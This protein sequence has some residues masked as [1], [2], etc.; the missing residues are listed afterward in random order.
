MTNLGR[1]V[2]CFLVL[3]AAAAGGQAPSTPDQ[4]V[5]SPD[6]RSRDQEISLGNALAAQFLR[7]TPTLDDNAAFLDYVKRVGANLAAQ[8]PG[9]WTYQ[10]YLISGDVGCSSDEPTVFP[11]GHIFVPQGLI[12]A[13]RNEAEFV[14]MLAH[15]M[16]H[17]AEPHDIPVESK[18]AQASARLS[19]I[20]ATAG[21]PL[22]AVGCQEFVRPL[23]F[24]KLS[25]IWERGAD[26]LAVQAMAA[27]GYDPAGL[28]SY[29]DR[30]RPV[31]KTGQFN[32]MFSALPSADERIATIQKEILGLPVRTYPASDEFVRLQAEFKPATFKKPSDA[33]TLNRKTSPDLSH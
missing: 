18:E 22:S 30:V 10:F 27:A 26:R 11:G 3:A 13:A 7:A 17:V 5:S 24:M 12:L 9:A 19:L 6:K 25:P 20:F 4:D 14:G 8:L 23:A 15:A 21:W 31:K 2:V 33:P 29:L 16:G 28:C 32:K 1:D